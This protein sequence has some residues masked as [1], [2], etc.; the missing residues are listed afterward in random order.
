[1]TYLESFLLPLYRWVDQNRTALFRFLVIPSVLIAVAFLVPKMFVG[2]RYPALMLVALLFLVV[3]IVFLRRPIL[4][5]I[6]IFLVGMFIPFVGPSGLNAA[7]GVVALMLG[8]WL[9]KMM[10]EERQIRVDPFPSHLTHL[11]LY[12]HFDLRSCNRTAAL[13]CQCQARSA[14]YPTGW[15]QRLYPLCWGLPVSCPPGAGCGPV[16][17]NYLDI[18]CSGCNLRFWA[19]FG[20]GIYRSH[21]PF[22]LYCWKH[23][24]DVVCGVGI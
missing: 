14:G 20:M 1:M 19:S 13:V 24:L 4:G 8:L 15:I 7:V 23:V 17:S 2:N 16:A 22:R 10:V 3:L 18:Y 5:L 21:L 12:S 6:A 11:Y 9:L